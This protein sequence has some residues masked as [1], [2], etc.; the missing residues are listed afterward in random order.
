MHAA[1]GRSRRRPGVFRKAMCG[2][3]P[4]CTRATHAL[5][6]ATYEVGC[7]GRRKAIAA[8]LWQSRGPMAPR[9]YAAAVYFNQYTYH[10]SGR[11]WIATKHSAAIRTTDLSEQSD[12]QL[13]W[14]DTRPPCPAP[15]PPFPAPSG[16]FRRRNCRVVA[17][18]LLPFT[19]RVHR[20]PRSRRV[21]PVLH[22]HMGNHPGMASGSLRL[23]ASG[24]GKE[25]NSKIARIFF[26]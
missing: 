21:L 11:N 20:P 18:P 17:S 14:E 15:I 5:I 25:G 6:R 23:M 16:F 13:A 8:R 12:S 4:C 26:R 19:P 3:R 2:L 24:N 10:S 1:R 9:T 7:Y 22:T